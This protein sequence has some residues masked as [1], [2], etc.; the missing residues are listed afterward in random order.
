MYNKVGEICLIISYVN[1]TSLHYENRKLFLSKTLEG[2]VVS[3][4]SRKEPII[5]D[6]DACH[7][8]RN[9]SELKKSDQSD[10]LLFCLLQKE[11]LGWGNDHLSALQLT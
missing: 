10:K 11:S 1:N 2:A 6:F 9:V 8:A 5:S 7:T 3:L 4:I